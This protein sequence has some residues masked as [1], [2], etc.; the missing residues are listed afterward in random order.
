MAEAIKEAAA[1]IAD[2]TKLKAQVRRGAAR[3]TH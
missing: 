3:R 1:E 2:I